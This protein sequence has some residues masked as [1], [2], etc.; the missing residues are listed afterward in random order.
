MITNLYFQFSLFNNWKKKH[1]RKILACIARL[2]LFINHNNNQ[3]QNVIQR[4]PEIQLYKKLFPDEK[5]T[6]EIKERNHNR[7]ASSYRTLLRDSQQSLWAEILNIITDVRTRTNFSNT[8]IASSCFR[9][10]SSFAL[11]LLR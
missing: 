6:F 7:K 5:Y 10:A 8:A 2:I 9:S 11:A 4:T 3:F 1:W